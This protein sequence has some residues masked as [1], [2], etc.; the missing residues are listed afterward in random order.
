MKGKRKGEGEKEGEEKVTR[1]ET[2]YKKAE[3][4]T[5]NEEV[6]WG[7]LYTCTPVYSIQPFKHFSVVCREVFLNQSKFNQK[8]KRR[9]EKKR[10]EK[11]REELK[12]TLGRVSSGFMAK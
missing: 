3:Q 12:D 7:S 6:K 5:F 4:C 11:R 9:E 10:D 8:I 2:K 1:G